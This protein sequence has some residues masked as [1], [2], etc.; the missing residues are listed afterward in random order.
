M[1]RFLALGGHAMAPHGMN[2]R[3][4]L[5]VL[6]MVWVMWSCAVDAVSGD[7]KGA[8]KATAHGTDP[9]S[10]SNG[11]SLT[12]HGGEGVLSGEQG[13]H[14]Q[15]ESSLQALVGGWSYQA[16]RVELHGP[17][18]IGETWFLVQGKSGFTGTEGRWR[19]L[20]GEMTTCGGLVWKFTWRN[21]SSKIERTIQTVYDRMSEVFF[22]R[23][24]TQRSADN[25]PA[26]TRAG[27]LGV[28]VSLV[29]ERAADHGVNIVDQVGE[30]LDQVTV[31]SGLSW[32]RVDGA[33]F[34]RAVLEASILDDDATSLQHAVDLWRSD[35]RDLNAFWSRHIALTSRVD[36][37][38]V[39]RRGLSSCEITGRA[40]L[41]SSAMAQE[42][43]QRARR[44]RTE[45]R[46]DLITENNVNE[47]GRTMLDYSVPRWHLAWANDNGKRCD[48]VGFE[49]DSL[50]VL[51]WAPKGDEPLQHHTVDVSD[52]ATVTVVMGTA[53]Q[54]YVALL[55]NHGDTES[56]VQT[57]TI[58]LYKTKDYVHAVKAAI[59]FGDPGF[60]LPHATIVLNEMSE[61]SSLAILD[62]RL[63][64]RRPTGPDKRP[65]WHASASVEN[66]GQVAYEELALDSEPALGRR[67]AI[68][69][70]SSG[71]VSR[72]FAHR[73]HGSDSL[74]GPATLSSFVISGDGKALADVKHVS[75]PEGTVISAHAVTRVNRK[76][77]IVVDSADTDGV[78]AYAREFDLDAHW[79]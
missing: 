38:G 30:I 77:W 39:V 7:T 26:D 68:T 45:V 72:A 47:V 65:A 20:E 74:D 10:L 27:V 34:D 75:F 54:N 58:Q 15:C 76:G 62:D 40:Y 53:S 36:G 50:H 17:E 24:G 79:P 21:V 37:V 9:I 28:L 25:S 43:T 13:D 52:K 31:A 4:P 2:N 73:V 22:D 12:V 55:V 35:L 69:S 56:G 57:R 41:L 29:A 64:W 14:N 49:P 44:K 46:M 18:G 78:R 51:T 67:V 11:W 3:T 71:G 42:R 6:V 19:V 8:Q 1:W 59:P 63:L 33:A 70:L 16:V 48:F 66:A 23:T 32:E 60:P 61:P 5:W